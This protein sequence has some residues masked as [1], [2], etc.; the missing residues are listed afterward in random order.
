MPRKKMWLELFTKSQVS[1]IRMPADGDSL[2]NESVCEIKGVEEQFPVAPQRLL[3][4]FQACGERSD[5]LDEISIRILK[6]KQADVLGKAFGQNLRTLGIWFVAK[7]LG[8]FENEV[9][10]LYENG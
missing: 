4:G 10:V 5:Y 2:W 6:H 1:I 9:H 3:L 8:S 7:L